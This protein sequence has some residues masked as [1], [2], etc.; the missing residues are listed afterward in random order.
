M[1]ILR[2]VSTCTCLT[3][4]VRHMVSAD[5]KHRKECLGLVILMNKTD[6][7]IWDD[8]RQMHCSDQPSGGDDG[9]EKANQPRARSENLHISY[10]I[11]GLEHPQQSSLSA[12]RGHLRFLRE[13]L[14]F[15]PIS[16]QPTVGLDTAAGMFNRCPIQSYVDKKRYMRRS[17]IVSHVSYPYAAKRLCTHIHSHLLARLESGLKRRKRDAP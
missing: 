7:W 8:S 2:E 9:L 1:T 12:K 10:L 14:M 17:L 15:S 13:N 5:S 4:V 3:S 6:K 11:S 16:R